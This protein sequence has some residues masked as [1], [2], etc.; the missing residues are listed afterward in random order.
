MVWLDGLDVPLVALF[1]ST[2]RDDHPDDASC[3]ALARYGSGL[4]PVG[5]RGTGDATFAQL[6][7]V[8]LLLPKGFTTLSYRSSDERFELA[9]HDVVVVPGW[10]SYT[11]EAREDL[12]LFNYSDRAAQEKLCFFRE[13]R[14]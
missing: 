7:S 2:F 11:L 12:V 5:Y 4:L 6:A 3:D 9:P 1:N 10:M 8:Q 14:L 13:Q